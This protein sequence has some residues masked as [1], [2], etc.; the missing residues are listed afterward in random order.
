M[1]NRAIKKNRYFL[2]FLKIILT[3]VILVSPTT[4]AQNTKIT[5][6]PD[7]S[8][9][10]GSLGIMQFVIVPLGKS[11]NLEFYKS[12]I[13]QLCKNKKTCFLNFFTNSTNQKISFPLN[14][15]ILAEPTLMFKKSAKHQ[16]TSFEWSC[17][18]NLAVKNCF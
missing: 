6:L 1:I 14:D 18:L 12:T 15:K 7:G 3:S 13:K 17:R 5:T 11:K 2:V 9:V 10:A 16:N 4:Q 8:I